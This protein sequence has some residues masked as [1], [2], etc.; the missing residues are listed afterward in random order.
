MAVN[1]RT[2]FVDHRTGKIIRICR[3]EC[4]QLVWA[5]EKKLRGSRCEELRALAP[6]MSA[7]VAALIPTEIDFA[8]RQI[9]GLYRLAAP[10]LCACGRSF[11]LTCPQLRHSQTCVP[12]LRTMTSLNLPPQFGHMR[13][14]FMLPAFSPARLNRL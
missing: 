2:A 3:C 12:L 10:G 4:G 1:L 5:T 13:V 11:Q 9:V 6:L 7:T 8:H 14:W